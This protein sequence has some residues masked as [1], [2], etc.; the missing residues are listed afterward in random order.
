[1]KTR[2]TLILLVVL[3][4]GSAA[5]AQKR[6]V[7]AIAFYNVE[8]LFDAVDDPNN[9]GDN[10]FLPDGSYGWTQERF[11][12]KKEKIGWVLSKMANGADIIGLAELENLF[13]VQELIA[14]P[15]L[16]KMGY[17]LVHKESPDY[18]GIDVGLIYKPDRFK[19]LDYRAIRFPDTTYQSRDVL[20]VK[21]LYFGDTLHVFVNHWPSRLGG[22]A[23]KRELQGAALREEVNVLLAKNPQA[24]IVIMG[25]LNDD[26]INKSVKKDLWAGGDPVKLEPGEL[27][28]PSAAT[29][30][31]GYGT[32]MYRGT[33]NLFDQIIVSQGLMKG[34]GIT[35]QPGSFSV[36]G[37]DEMR[38]QAG[39]SAG[40]PL[41]TTS[42]GVYQNGYSDHFPTYILIQK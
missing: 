30:K 2:I 16:A 14:N 26:P 31:Q 19:L 8:N 33:W 15:Q 35:Y 1:M 20:H 34:D 24:K 11:E 41:R 28:N 25:D 12:N 13:V 40:G 4:G 37:P 36:F 29:F 23:D 38:V 3:M 32:L 9:E 39:E 6:T 17:Q 5:D 18:R 22:K 10:D 42:R 21:G 7:G 27:F